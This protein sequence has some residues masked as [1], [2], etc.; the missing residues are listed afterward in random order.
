MCKSCGGTGLYVGMAE[1]DGA[2]I[3]CHTCK[4]TGC[5]KFRYEYDEFTGRIDRPGVARVYETNPGICIGTGRGHRLE[6][7]GGIPLKEWEAG[8]PF[9]SGTENRK[10]TCPC[11]WFQNADYKRKPKWPECDSSLG[12]SFSGCTH[13]RDKEKCWERFDNENLTKDSAQPSR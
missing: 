8:L 9:V 3:M 12:C 4:G 13:F 2:A 6:D 5:H 11:W 10:F 1:R 7:F